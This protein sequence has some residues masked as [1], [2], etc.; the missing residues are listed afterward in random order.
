LFRL[1]GISAAIG[2]IGAEKP[3]NPRRRPCKAGGM[4]LSPTER[5]DQSGAFVA[6]AQFGGLELS[7]TSNGPL[8]GRTC[9]VKD[10]FDIAGVATGPVLLDRPK[11]HPG[12]SR[13]LIA[14]DLF[15]AADPSVAA[16]LQPALK[17]V[18]DAMGMTPDEIALGPLDAWRKAF[19]VLQSAEIW[20]THG[21]WVTQAQPDFG[22]GVRERFAA[23]AAI[24]PD[25][26]ANAE[27]QRKDIRARLDDLLGGDALLLL[28][29]MP[30]P[31]PLRAASPQERDA[32]RARALN[33]LCPAGLAGLPQI[34]MPLGEADGAPAG[35]SLLGPRG[36]DE[37][38]LELVR[39][40]A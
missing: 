1:S 20:A 31:A 9:A 18:A 24:T 27:A 37:A 10:M 40:I 13:L 29:T 4:T 7:A 12:F 6:H 3:L 28:P 14:Q 11:A 36:A 8:T 33:G 5:A 21:A 25:E 34:S 23:A 19:T 39:R 17:R 16:G 26:I 22:P 15:E 2:Q 35:L 32:F 38:L 30:C